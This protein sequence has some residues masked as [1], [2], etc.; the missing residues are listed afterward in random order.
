M[1]LSMTLCIYLKNTNSG[2]SP[3][4][5]SDILCGQSAGLNLC[6]N[7]AHPIRL[8][9]NRF[10]EPTTPSIEIS[11]T[12]TKNVAINAPL[13]ITG[14]ASVGGNLTVT[15]GKVENPTLKFPGTDANDSIV[16]QNTLGSEVARFY[17]DYR[18]TFNGNTNPNL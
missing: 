2:A 10:T 18:C 12:G 16:I 8:N 13:T 4:E 3:T 11:G 9:A 5:E 6:T 17:N 7:T 15:G 14:N 1:S